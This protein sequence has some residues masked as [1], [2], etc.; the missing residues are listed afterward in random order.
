[1]ND[2]AGEQIIGR[3]FNLLALPLPGLYAPP[4]GDA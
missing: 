4:K 1:M 3:G 2:R